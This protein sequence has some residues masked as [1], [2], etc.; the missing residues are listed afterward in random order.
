MHPSTSTVEANHSKLCLQ[1]KNSEGSREN[2][3][4]VSDHVYVYIY[5]YYSGTIF[6]LS[7]NSS[8]SRTLLAFHSWRSR[9][10]TASTMRVLK[11]N[12]PPKRDHLEKTPSSESPAMAVIWPN[13]VA[14]A[15]NRARGVDFMGSGAYT[16]FPS[17]LGVPNPR[18]APQKRSR[19]KATLQ[20][21]APATHNPRA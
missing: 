6:A 3:R 10:R 17:V 20:G 11:P 13:T 7:S 15:K 5:N 19:N 18:E 9:K 14:R 8:S 1:L 2:Q 4:I 21:K 12:N 16:A